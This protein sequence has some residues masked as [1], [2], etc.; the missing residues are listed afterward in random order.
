MCHQ[1]FVSLSESCG[2]CN[3]PIFM[4]HGTGI[5]CPVVYWCHYQTGNAEK[6]SLDPGNW[7]FSLFYLQFTVKLLI[8]GS[9]LSYLFTQMKIRKWTLFSKEAGT[10]YLSG[11]YTLATHPHFLVGRIF[12][13]FFHAKHLSCLAIYIFFS[14]QYFVPHSLHVNFIVWLLSVL[15]WRHFIK[16]YCDIIG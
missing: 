5:S 12:K 9:P 10:A 8:D 13:T 2:T 3:P 6:L 4:P 15:G 14:G 16:I 1:R 7:H 11:P